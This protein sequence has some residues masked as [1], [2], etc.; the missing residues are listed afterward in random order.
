[1]IYM[2]GQVEDYDGWR[3]MGNDGW[4]WQ[5]VLPYFLKSEDYAFAPTRSMPRAE[6][7]GSRTFA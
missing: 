7:G 3:Q 4:S 1:M 5:D 6:N 2:R